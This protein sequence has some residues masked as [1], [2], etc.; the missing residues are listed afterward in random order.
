MT[1]RSL[2]R[3]PA[4]T[5]ATFRVAVCALTVG[6]STPVLAQSAQA[7]S[8]QVAATYSTLRADNRSIVGVGIA[9]QL[10]YNR[11]LATENRGTISLGAGGEYALHRSGDDRLHVAGIFI[12]PRWALPFSAGCAFP[13][14]S[15]RA[16]V[17]RVIADFDARDD[18]SA[19]GY[20]VG[21]GPGVTFRMTRTANLDVGV[22]LQRQQFAS[23]RGT[24]FG[25]SMTYAAR[26]G[27][28]LGYPR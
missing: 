17:Q 12:E 9:P 28:S 4:L 14:I 25:P 2:V 27:V 24:R 10:R 7:F 20:A 13:F 26:L 11:V 15:A 18:G 16:A 22:Q 23:I 1:T 21:A 5:R 19:T 6:C 8:V 3:L